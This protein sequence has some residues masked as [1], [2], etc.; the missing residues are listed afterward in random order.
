MIDAM[1]VVEAYMTD[2]EEFKRVHREMGNQA[3]DEE[4]YAL[5]AFCMSKSWCQKRHLKRPVKTTI[6][7]MECHDHKK[8][9]AYHFFLA[10]RWCETHD[11]SLAEKMALLDMLAADLL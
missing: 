7:E 10:A 6:Y 4:L 11:P 1:K 5:N 8:L 9:N 3:T 2:R